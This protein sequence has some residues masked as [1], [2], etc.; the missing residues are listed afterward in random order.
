[1]ISRL[2]CI[3]F[4]LRPRPYNFAVPGKVASFAAWSCYRAC[5]DQ[6]KRG[7]SPRK[8]YNLWLKKVNAKVCNILKR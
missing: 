7:S 1:M 3:A 2:A 8:E 4:K 5:E 6:S